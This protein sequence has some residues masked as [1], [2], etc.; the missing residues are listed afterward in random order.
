V[1]AGRGIGVD[2]AVFDRQG[3]LLTRSGVVG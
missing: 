2:V 3:A 1:V